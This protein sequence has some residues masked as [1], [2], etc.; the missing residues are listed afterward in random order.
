MSTGIFLSNITQ[1]LEYDR[2][3]PFPDPN[4]I[5]AFSFDINFIRSY[6][7]STFVPPDTVKRSIFFISACKKNTTTAICSRRRDRIYQK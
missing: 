6:Y 4:G 2:T 5:L 3:I 1:N 7:L